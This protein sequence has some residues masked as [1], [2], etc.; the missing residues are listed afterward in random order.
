MS[1]RKTKK[2]ETSGDLNL[3]VKR[4]DANKLGEVLL[5]YVNVIAFL[6]GAVW[7]SMTKYIGLANISIPPHFF[8]GTS[9]LLRLANLLLCDSVPRSS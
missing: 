6:V 1:S 3:L 5:N 4:A 7:F 8:I 2:A 9:P